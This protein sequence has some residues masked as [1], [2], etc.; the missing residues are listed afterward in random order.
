MC[1]PV[2]IDPYTGGYLGQRHELDGWSAGPKP[3]APDVRQRRPR[4]ASCHSL[5]HHSRA[6]SYP[7]ASVRVGIGNLIGWRRHGCWCTAREQ[8]LPVVAAG[9]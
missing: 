6:V 8:G 4:P 2:F 9:H 1:H 7:D 5:G 3:V